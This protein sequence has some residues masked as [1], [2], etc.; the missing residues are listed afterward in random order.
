M[1]IEYTGR[2]F[3]ITA[4]LRQQADSAFEQISKMVSESAS[5]HVILSVDKYRNTAEVT[6]TTRTQD[7]V[8]SCESDQME[9]A[10]HDCLAKIEQ[11]VI[12]YKDKRNGE[13][14][15]PHLGPGDEELTPAAAKPVAELH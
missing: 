1:K 12:R 13:K 8:S 10:L 9:T 14:R 3:T 2:Q 5:A 4:K 6:L 11:Q 15:H 7:Y